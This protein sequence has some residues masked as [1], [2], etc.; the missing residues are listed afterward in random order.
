MSDSNDGDNLSDG[1]PDDPNSGS[2]PGDPN[3]GDPNAGDANL[4]GQAGAA[5]P[6]HLSGQVRSQH[7]SARV[8]EGISRGVFSTG[9]IL[10]TGAS[11]FVVDFIQN[12]GQPV[13]VVA[14]VVVP[15]GL[16]HQFIDALRKN[17][18]IYTQR[19]GAP[20]MPQVPAAQQQPQQRRMGV[21][22]I[23]DE[24]KIPDELLSGVYANGLMI[25][26][27]ATEFRLDFLT[28]LFPHSAVSCRVFL[29]SPQIPRTIDSLHATLQ[30][31]Q[32]R[33]LEQRQQQQPPPTDEN[34]QPPQDSS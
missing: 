9:V 24:L 2:N 17:L 33:V 22:E 26:H 25:G 1:V 19:Y 29:S 12:L 27:T 23:Y 4:G 30:A 7:V 6:S 15:H 16:M 14:R 10:I 21:Q 31:F 18:E 8:P 28:N 32:Q 20:N 11:E 13:Q 3:A 5:D 34:P